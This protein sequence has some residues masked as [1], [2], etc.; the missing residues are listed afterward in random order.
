MSLQITL[1]PSE[2]LKLRQQSKLIKELVRETHFSLIEVEALCVIYFK[3]LNEN[4]VKR[5]QLDRMQFRAMFHSC[6]H[7]NDD[8]LIDRAFVYLDKGTT[9][10]VTLDT[11]VKTMSIFLRGSLDE[12]MK[13]CFA[14]YD[15]NGDG[16]IKRNEVILLFGKCFIGEY[17]EDVEL[18]VKDLADIMVRKMDLDTDGIITFED[19]RQSV[20]RQPELL[21]CFGRCLPERVC[22][23]TFLQTFTNENTR[24]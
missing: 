6:F 9:T 11:F 10:Y 21:E 19:Y 12:K 4:N 24:F 13:Y 8:F 23:Y 3:F 2:E 18:A 20:L 16:K 17:E 1:E 14:V 5:S 7:I 15:L 22:A